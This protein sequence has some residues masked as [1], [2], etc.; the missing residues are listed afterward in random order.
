LIYKSGKKEIHICARLDRN[1]A[2][3]VSVDERGKNPI[4]LDSR[5]GNGDPNLLAGEHCLIWCNG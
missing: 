1:S 2:D 4:L 5:L 3:C